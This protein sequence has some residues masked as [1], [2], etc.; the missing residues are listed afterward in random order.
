MVVNLTS[1]QV[2]VYIVNRYKGLFFF[3]LNKDLTVCNM[4]LQTKPL[5]Q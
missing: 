1:L 5:T 4:R 3:F 2:T